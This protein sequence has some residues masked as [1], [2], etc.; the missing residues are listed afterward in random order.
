M[1]NTLVTGY[2]YIGLV[3]MAL[4][5][6]CECYTAL[7]RNA[8]KWSTD[9]NVSVLRGVTT[10]IV[11]GVALICMAIVLWPDMVCRVLRRW[12]AR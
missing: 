8:R 12:W 10:L 2:L 11:C 3:V 9:H 1:T 7:V 6:I 5:I 4:R